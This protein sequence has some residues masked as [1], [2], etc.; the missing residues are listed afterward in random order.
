ME[1]KR[2]AARVQQ[3]FLHG[4]FILMF[5]V[6]LVK[7]IGA[8]FKIPLS[9]IITE[10]GMGYFST[11]Y[12]FFNVLFSLST[13]GFPVAVARLTAAED[14]SGHFRDVRQIKA[15]ALP[16]F[17][18][19]GVVCAALMAGFA[20]LYTRLVQSPGALFAMLALAPC[21][22]LCSVSSVYRGYFE[23]LR[24]M[25]PTA[26]SQ[27]AESLGKLVFGLSG[28]VFVM[29]LGIQELQAGGTVFGYAVKNEAEGRQL[30]CALGAAAA[31]FG[32]TLGA[33]LGLLTLVIQ[34]CRDGITKTMLQ[35]APRPKSKGVWAKRLL[36]TA[37][38]ISLGAVAMSFSG[39]I[40]ASFLQTRI[41]HAMQTDPAPLLSMYAGAIPE[42]N[43]AAPETVPNYLFGCYNMA[44]TLFLLVPSVTQ[45]FGV[46]ALPS[47][48]RAFQTGD[49]Q[50]LK[51]AVEAVLRITFL[52]ALPMG[53][54]LSVLAQP[55]ALL[56]Y[57]ARPGTVIV[58]HVLTVLGAASV[59]AALCGPLNSILQ[60]MGHVELPVVLTLIG[61]FVKAA[62]DYTLAAMPKINVLGGTIGTLVC[63]AITS[64]LACM[65][66]RRIAS[67]KIDF[68][69]TFK[70]P[71]LASVCCGA[72]ALGAYKAWCMV[73]PKSRFS[74]LPA[75]LF[76]ALIYA[77][78]LLTT[79]GICEEDLKALPN[80]EK[81]TKRLEKYLQKA[82]G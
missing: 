28:A 19:I 6:L 64:V 18:A 50:K 11:A 5:G 72:A 7:A 40:D 27:V 39:L 66:I 32:V 22:A 70:K 62:L 58:G 46:S 56:I 12:S 51:R 68:F 42:G 26:R 25:L 23:G 8:L 29:R 3:G 81:I 73:L 45:S 75:V 31:I 76:G 34:S 59:F 47:V 2:P 9:G 65:A 41:A 16:V 60:A 69:S 21:A 17:S 38:P 79:R 30:I 20:P 24:N 37:L 1:Q 53:V 67:V 63:Y 80:G 35:S 14:A 57:G 49:P 4:A 13:V 78:F 52:T 15:A 48:T 77:I 10:D 74:A 61:L 43:L 33:V 54:G 71:F 36:R 55:V 82:G 44:L